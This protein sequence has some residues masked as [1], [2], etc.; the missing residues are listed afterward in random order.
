MADQKTGLGCLFAC[1]IIFRRKRGELVLIRA[2]WFLKLGDFVEKESIVKCSFLGE[3]K[4]NL[5]A[6]GE[7]EEEMIQ[8]R[9]GS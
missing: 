2:F 6:F 1:K 3:K 8:R 9:N 5:E 7:M 4:A